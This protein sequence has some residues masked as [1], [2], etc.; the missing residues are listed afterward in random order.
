MRE[1]AMKR[2]LCVAA[3][4]AVLTAVP[5]GAQTIEITPVGERPSAIGSP[6]I[7]TGHV[8]IDHLVAGTD[9]TRATSA[10]VT[11]APGARSAWHSHPAGQFLIVTSGTGWVQERGGER[12][13]IRPGDVIWT[14]P[15]L[16]HWHGAGEA[17]GMSHIALQELVDGENV[18]WLEHVT[19]D[20]YRGST[21][22]DSEQ[23]E[24]R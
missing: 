16:E 3:A 5:T 11:F 24:R 18:R 17:N 9:H 4:F 6:D 23:G 7:F 2:I 12:R 1:V 13:Q 22:R 20:Q 14:P 8:V 15:G 21:S 19:E 10:L